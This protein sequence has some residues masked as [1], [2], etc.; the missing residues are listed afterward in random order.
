MSLPFLTTDDG[1]VILRAIQGTILTH[2]FRVHKL[3]LS[4]AS[5]VFKDMFTFP[6]PPEQ[7]HSDQPDIPIVDVSDSPQ[8]LDTILRF[9]YPGVELPT[10]TDLSTVSALL[11]AADKYNVASMRP[12][13]RGALKTFVDVEP[14]RVYTVAC[15]FGLWEEAKAAARLSTL[16]TIILSTDHEKDIR[17]ISGVDL[18]RLLLLS[19]SRE[20]V[21]RARIRAF[22]SLD[23]DLYYIHCARHWAD[24]ENFYA[25]LE[26]KLQDTLTKNPWLQFDDLNEVLDT[27]PDPPF[28]CKPGHRDMNGLETTCPLRPSF[29]RSGLRL[30]AK[31]LA[32]QNDL[33]LERA[34]EKE[35]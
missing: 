8:V 11:S 17:H 7:N 29:I 18:Y 21:G 9:I 13:L 35:F 20:N 14:F 23:P 25:L 6:Q 26:M 2:D 15:R 28:G 27:L 22:T 34:F 19:E 4:L 32:R 3:I 5:P 1:D 12:T 31:D 16:K 24:C 10:F 30:L 33:L